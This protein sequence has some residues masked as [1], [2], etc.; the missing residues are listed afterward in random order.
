MIWAPF[1]VCLFKIERLELE[2]ARSLENALG[3]ENI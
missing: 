2:N 1:L 3:A